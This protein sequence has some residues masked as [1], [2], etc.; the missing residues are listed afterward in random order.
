MAAQDLSPVAPDNK[1]WLKR[2]ISLWQNCGLH[3]VFKFVRVE[4]LSPVPTS[5][6]NERNVE[7]PVLNSCWGDS[8]NF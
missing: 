2:W 1:N 6:H 4:A 5:F 8:Q 7:L 3:V